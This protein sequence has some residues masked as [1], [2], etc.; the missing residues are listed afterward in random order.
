MASGE[1]ASV[2]SAPSAAAS[3]PPAE[4]SAPVPPSGG[5]AGIDLGSLGALTS[6]LPLLN[7]MR[8]DDQ[9]TAL[10]RSLRP[11]LHGD[12]EKKLDDAIKMMQFMKVL[13]V[14]KDKGLF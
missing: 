13:P 11:Y 10:L 5:G 8:S 1:G 12:R 3:M 6:L 9:N 7:N 2:S 14:L 4:V